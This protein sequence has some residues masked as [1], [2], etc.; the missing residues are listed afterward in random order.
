MTDF[1]A[2]SA[3]TLPHLLRLLPEWLPGGRI[4][5]REYVTSNLSGGPGRS[6]SIN[7]KTGVWKDFSTD[8]GGGDPVSLYAAIQGIAQGEAA[9]KLAEDMG[10][11][12]TRSHQQ[13][14]IFKTYDSLVPGPAIPRPSP[15]KNMVG[16][17]V[18]MACMYRKGGKGMG[19]EGVS[20]EK[21]FKH[22]CLNPRFSWWS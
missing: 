16:I 2:I 5:G 21:G 15:S 12:G 13:G 9:R 19:K 14:K 1:R 8:D 3:H 11:N 18:G 22:F 6:L 10:I 20:K 17:G 7:L 4:E